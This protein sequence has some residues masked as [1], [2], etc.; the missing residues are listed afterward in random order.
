[1]EN[2]YKNSIFGRS[3]A[4]LVANEVDGEVLEAVRKALQTKGA[5]VKLIASSVGEIKSSKG[6]MIKVDYSFPTVSS[7]LFDAVFIPGEKLCAET[8]C[9]DPNAVLFVKEAYKHAKSIGASD[10]GI[11]L[12]EKAA[13]TSGVPNGSFEGPGII[14]DSGETVDKAF[15]DRFI[16]AICKH[17][18]PERTNMDMIIA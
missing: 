13:Y 6:K 14:V 18:F 3:V 12:I 5:T 11:S 4:I 17:R 15:V 7:A 2:T 16:V 10:G 8:L 9:A 1:M